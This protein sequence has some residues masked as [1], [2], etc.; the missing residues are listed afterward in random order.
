MQFSAERIQVETIRE[1]RQHPRRMGEGMVVIVNDRAYP[2][3]DVS[4]A[5]I[6]FQ[7][8]GHRV[9]DRLK[10]TLAMLADMSDCVEV[11]L[12]IKAAGG[13]ILRAEFQPTAKLMRYIVMHQSKVS[14]GQPAYFR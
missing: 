13:S 6:S 9:E 12:T 1:R 7:S 8:S 5:G 11:G 4:I 2:V 10:A 3:L 14:G